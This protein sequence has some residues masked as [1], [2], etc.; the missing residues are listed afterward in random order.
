MLGSPFRPSKV[1]DEIYDTMESY[2]A[3]SDL[4]NE[5]LVDAITDYFTNYNPAAEWKLCCSPWPNMA[6]GVCSVC[7][8]EDG[9]VHMVAFDYV[10]EV[11]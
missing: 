11:M 5:G 1:E 8:I 3:G 7:W 4:Y 2:V 6:G 10:K 9:H